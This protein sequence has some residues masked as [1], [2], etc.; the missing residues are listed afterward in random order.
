MKFRKQAAEKAK[1]EG[2]RFNYRESKAE[3]NINDIAK[4]GYLKL[5]DF[6][7]LSKIINDLSF[8]LIKMITFILPNP[9]N[10]AQIYLSVFTFCFF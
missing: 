5:M 8:D 9:K 2:K 3:A 6:C 7:C 10:E 1:T 4:I